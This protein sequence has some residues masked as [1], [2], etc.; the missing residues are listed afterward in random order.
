MSSWAVVGGGLLGMEMARQAATDGHEITLFEASDELGGLASS[1]ELGGV[2]WDRHY[3]VVTPTDDRTEDLLAE[4]DLT[5]R[6]ATTRTGCYGNGRH[7][8]VSNVGEF[9]RFPLLNPLD[10][11]R[12]A[13][14]MVYASRLTD[15]TKLSSIPVED[16][17]VRLSGRRVTDRFW[18]P[19]LR[20][21]LGD[22][23][24]D[25]SATFLWTII[26]RLYAARTSG[27]RTEQ[28]GYVPGGY[29]TII[30][31]M[32]A[33]L[34][35]E[36]IDVRL[37]APVLTVRSTAGPVIVETPS[38]SERFDQVVVT[39]AAPQAARM[40]DGLSDAETGA[41]EQVPYMGVVCASVVLTRP[42]TDF[43]VTNLI[44]ETPFTG[45]IEMTA[46]I[47]PAEVGGYHLVYLPRYVASDDPLLDATDE[48][49]ER[50]FLAGLKRLHP[51][52]EAEHVVAFAVSRPRYV[53]PVPVIGYA[54]RV[55][56]MDTSVPGVWTVNSSQI[57]DGTL[58]VD[59]TL[60]LADRAMDRIRAVV[61]R[62]NPQ[63]AVS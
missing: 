4:L 60:L 48:E 26:R 9:L 8:S 3:H 20:A 25:T 17:V 41:L 44:D 10:K 29:A 37:G 27:R 47:D 50:S 1:W 31:A 52:L 51:D 33:D 32:A 38:S 12:L 58:N 42:L 2:R 11:V 23:Y 61:S 14:T 28:L 49:I 30:D 55:P 63:E 22:R 62:T 7:H 5:L 19:L 24:R 16:W 54:D 40:I 18:L 43:Y 53:L 45:V 39:A 46:L 34:A 6:W 21:K 13:A 57:I 36:D 56:P 15:G 35:G 59:E